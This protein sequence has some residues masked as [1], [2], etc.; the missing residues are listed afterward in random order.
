MSETE[1]VRCGATDDRDHGIVVGLLDPLNETV[2]N[3]C[4]SDEL[5]R[6]TTMSEREAQ[7]AAL[8]QLGGHSHAE[9]ADI[10]DI[11]ES[12]VGE[13]RRRITQKIRTAETTIDELD[14]LR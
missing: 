1:C 8:K 4:R 11:D 3:V 9:V 6:E 10:L 7:V 12:T 2:C 13:Y 5:V 14:G